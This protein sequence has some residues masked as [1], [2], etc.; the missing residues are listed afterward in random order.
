MVKRRIDMKA[1]DK[2]LYACKE[3]FELIGCFNIVSKDNNMPCEF[4][5]VNERCNMRAVPVKY[6]ELFEV[7]KEGLCNSCYE[8][9]QNEKMSAVSV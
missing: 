3:C 5:K 1:T 7:R 6:A 4:C 9:R 8:R 2:A